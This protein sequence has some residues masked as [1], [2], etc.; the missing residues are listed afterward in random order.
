[1]RQT[2][3]TWTERDEDG[4]AMVE[5]LCSGSRLQRTNE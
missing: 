4:A 1:M 3:G 5:S 2:F